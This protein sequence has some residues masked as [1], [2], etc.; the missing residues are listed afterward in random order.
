LKRSILALAAIVALLMVVTIPAVADAST[1]YANLELLAK[2]TIKDSDWDG[3]RS[4]VRSSTFITTS[5]HNFSLGFNTWN[6]SGYA[7]IRDAA[8]EAMNIT[9]AQ[10]YI[11]LSSGCVFGND[12]LHVKR[13][14]VTYFN[15]DS[16]ILSIYDPEPVSFPSPP[17]SITTTPTDNND[18]ISVDQREA[19]SFAML[20]VVVVV[21]ITVLLLW[22]RAIRG[23]MPDKVEYLTPSFCTHCG[24]LMS[25]TSDI[26]PLCEARKG[27]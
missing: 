8:G 11:P 4:N 15:S 22:Y 26:C 19:F 10:A 16:A 21:L 13:Q 7:V 14:G 12:Q 2:G 3:V 20:A 9:G 6:Q 17:R 5:D 18:L 27:Q 23:A 1:D 25:E 24:T